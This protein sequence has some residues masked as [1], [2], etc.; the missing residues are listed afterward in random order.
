[1]GSEMCIRDRWWWGSFHENF[2]TTTG[3]PSGQ[4]RCL[5]GRRSA[6]QVQ[7]HRGRLREGVERTDPAL[8]GRPAAV[9]EPHGARR[10]SQVRRAG[11]RARAETLPLRGGA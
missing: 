6:L 2:P 9:A 7:P 8:P 11:L 10:A 1:M 3:E 4:Q 5:L